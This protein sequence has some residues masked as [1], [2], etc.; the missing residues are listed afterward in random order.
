M[1]LPDLHFT[2]H[3]LGV[4]VGDGASNEGDK[5][6]RFLKSTYCK[7]LLSTFESWLL[8]IIINDQRLQI[9]LENVPG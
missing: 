4:G 5:C 3:G 1:H 6:M 9:S 7:P 2:A 8:I